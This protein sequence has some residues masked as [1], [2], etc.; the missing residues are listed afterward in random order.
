MNQTQH[1]TTSNAHLQTWVSREFKERFARVAKAQ[2]LSESAL[3][4]RLLEK[5]VPTD[6]LPD[7][8]LIAPVEEVPSARRVSVRLRADDLHFLRERARARS[9][10]T[11]TYISYLVRS[12]LRAQAPLP[13]QELAALKRSV[14]EIGAIGRNINQIA[15][16]VNQQQWPSGPDAAVLSEMV[17][18]LAATR[19]HIKAL[20]NANLASWDSGHGTT[21]D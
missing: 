21:S 6:R 14:A 1:L 16:A 8:V 3:L 12:H 15:R 18:V 10:P 4:R 13:T 11:S 9:L 17:R 19:A 2:G 7:C 20:I 5:I